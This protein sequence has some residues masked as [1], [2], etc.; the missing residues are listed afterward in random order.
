MIN[1]I[2]EVF[3]ILKNY[4]FLKI[5]IEALLSVYLNLTK[6]PIFPITTLIIRQIIFSFF[7][8]KNYFFIYM[9]IFINL[10]QRFIKINI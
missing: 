9:Y 6:P 3:F 7:L 2:T 8:N 1:T 10:F 4:P 5:F